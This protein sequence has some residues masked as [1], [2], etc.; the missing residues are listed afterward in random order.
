MTLSTYPPAT[1]DFLQT[2]HSHSDAD[3]SSSGTVVETA[4]KYP[5]QEFGHLSEENSVP[6]SVGSEHLW[7]VQVKYLVSLRC[8]CLERHAAAPYHLTSTVHGPKK[9]SRARIVIF[10]IFR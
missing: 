5:V 1:S 7:H 2:L 9:R 3:N 6:N 8:C 4:D 10:V